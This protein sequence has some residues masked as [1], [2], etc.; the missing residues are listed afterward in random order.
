M[1]AHARR[2]LLEVTPLAGV[3]IEILQDPAR[4]IQQFVTPLAG[5][6]IEMSVGAVGGVTTP[7]VTPLAGVWIEIRRE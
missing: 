5:V 6:W 1:T 4:V 7:M 3:W 2:R